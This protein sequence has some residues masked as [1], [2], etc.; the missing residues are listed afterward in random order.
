MIHKKIAE[1]T[2]LSTAELEESNYR[3]LQHFVT[4]GT[5]LHYDKLTK[6]VGTQA[7][8]LMTSTAAPVT[9]QPFPNHERYHVS[10]LSE[11][12]KLEMT[13]AAAE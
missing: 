5:L 2:A 13:H 9:R 3:M 8:S 6:L 1:L 4:S 7:I 10:I 11:Q 12:E